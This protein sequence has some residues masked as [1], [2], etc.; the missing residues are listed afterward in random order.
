MKWLSS[1]V[2]CFM[3]RSSTRIHNELFLD[4]YPTDPGMCHKRNLRTFLAGQ[5][6][7]RA[8]WPIGNPERQVYNFPGNQILTFVWR[9]DDQEQARTVANHFASSVVSTRKTRRNLVAFHD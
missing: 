4:I 7:N 5:Y 2:S 6:A 8:K 9:I 1:A 3:T